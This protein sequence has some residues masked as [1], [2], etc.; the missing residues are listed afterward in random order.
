MEP[1]GHILAHPLERRLTHAVHHMALDYWLQCRRSAGGTPGRQDIDPLDIPG[2][3]PW[4]T[5]VDVHRRDGGLRFRQ[6]LVGTAVVAMRERDS[7]GMWFDE[8]YGPEKLAFLQPALAA[9][10]QTAQP[11][12]IRDNL[13][14]IGKPHRNMYTLILPLAADR[15]RVDML[16]AVS[17]SD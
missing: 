17:H 10:V 3:L 1:M 15:R 4:V 8:V 16:M 2:L 7:T 12:V 13:R 9:V 14:D 6:R 11:D 5:L